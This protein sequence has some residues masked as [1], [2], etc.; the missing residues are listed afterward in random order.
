MTHG[1]SQH[2][3][4]QDSY[5]AVSTQH[6]LLPG[7]HTWEKEWRGKRRAGGY[8][9]LRITLDPA[10]VTRTTKEGPNHSMDTNT[11]FLQFFPNSVTPPKRLCTPSAHPPPTLL[12]RS[13]SQYCALDESASVC[14]KGRVVHGV[15]WDRHSAKATGPSTQLILA[16]QCRAHTHACTRAVNENVLFDFR[17]QLEK[18]NRII[19]WKQQHYY[20]TALNLQ[21]NFHWF[22]NKM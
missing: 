6:W 10:H 16:K 19:L 18:I 21:H 7:S 2:S 13:V 20:R 22:E 4:T 14:V 1:H 5:W 17:I 8:S 12:L 15:A 9:V 11:H 3:Q